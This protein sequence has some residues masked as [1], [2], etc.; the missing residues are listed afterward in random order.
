[1]NDIERQRYSRQIF[2][3]QIGEAGQQRLVD[4][5]V[6]VVGLGGLG[7]PVAMYLAAAGVGTL[8]LVDF[9]RVE[10]SNLQRQIIHGEADVGRLK[11]ESAAATIAGLNRD[12][13]VETIPR[14]LDDEELVETTRGCQVVVDASDNFET[15]YALNRAC[16]STGVPLVSGAA[17]AWDGQ[18]AVFDP[19]R[20]GSPCYHCLYPDDGG[21]GE[22]CDQAGI[23]APLLGMVGSTQAAEVLKL[24]IG[25]G[26]TLAGRL[27]LLDALGMSIRILGIPRDPG[28]PVCGTQPH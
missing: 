12:T 3:P 7:S 28:C 2:L 25:T 27:M 4:A 10:L 1:M 9:D 24:I 23:F 21:P 15:R 16:V 8:V 22:T 5:R 26:E 6:M 11:V 18:V 14:A 19:R 17:T 13:G 20:D